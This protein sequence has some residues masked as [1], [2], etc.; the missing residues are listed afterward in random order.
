MNQK[1]TDDSDLDDAPLALQKSVEVC[2][3][4]DGVSRAQW[5]LLRGTESLKNLEIFAKSGFFTKL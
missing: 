3:A 1:K 4:L 2:G 5:A